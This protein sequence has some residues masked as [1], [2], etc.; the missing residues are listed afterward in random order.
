MAYGLLDQNNILIQ[1]DVEPHNGFIQIP[2]NAI[3]GQETTDGGASFHDVLATQVTA[4]EI[5]KMAELSSAYATTITANIQFTTAGPVTATFQANEDVID[6]LEKCIIAFG[7]TGVVP[8]GFYFVDASNAHVTFTYADLR[9]LARAIGDRGWA[10]A[11]NLQT[12]KAAVRTAV[13]ANDVAAI[14]AVTW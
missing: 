6:D 2:D 13:A 9:G 7:D 8:V 11:D 4:A 14:N 5:A 1:K 3:C 12:K 10:A